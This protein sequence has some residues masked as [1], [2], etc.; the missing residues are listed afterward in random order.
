MKI[1]DR[2][3]IRELL[4]PFLFGLGAFTIL[5]F[6][7]ETLMGVARMVAESKAGLHL[8]ME[9]L[10]CR[11]PQV[12]VFTFPMAVLLSCLLAFGRLSGES[13]LTA[14]KAS[15]ISFFRIALPALGF[16]LCVSLFSHWLN[17]SI[18]P[19]R[20]K[21]A[22]DILVST[23]TNEDT[24]R[25]ALLTAPKP[26][27]N[28][29]E[30][31]VYAH[32]IN[33]E[34]QTMQGVFIHYF[35]ESMRRREIYAE[36]ARW[37]GHVWIL[38]HMRTVEYD[39]WQ[40]PIMEAVSEEGWTALSPDESPPAPDELNKR[41]FRPE[42]LSQK[43]LRQ[44]LKMLPAPEHED[45]KA[46]R[47]RNRFRVML[48][49]KAALPWTPLIFGAFAIP[50]GVRPHR[51][52]RS[53]GLGLSLLFILVYYVLMTMGMV[54]GESGSLDPQAGA[55]LPNLVFGVMGVGLLIDAS[56]R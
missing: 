18:V 50:L 15:G 5:F 35:Y 27:K 14:L 53:M 3:I 12:L 6:S 8:V 45:E 32:K 55:W 1:L 22:F 30:Q 17:E 51:A 20:M 23:Q 39:R 47:Q 24:F 48:H 21:R 34:E 44:S 13:E 46:V 7:V 25:Q 52:S 40:E 11:L 49:Q 38:H 29:M 33:L 43:E 10:L 37:D 19:D 41:E 28:G 42:E 9:Y 4:G 16:C 31:M 36:K 26:M 54:L 2:Y 56:R